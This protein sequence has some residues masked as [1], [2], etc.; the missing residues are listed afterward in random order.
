MQNQFGCPGGRLKFPVIA[1][2]RVEIASA[3]LQFPHA[4]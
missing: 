3:K 2:N 4:A 1:A